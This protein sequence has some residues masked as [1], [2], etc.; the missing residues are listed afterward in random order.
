MPVAR[1]RNQRRRHVTATMP[2]PAPAAAAG[3][4]RRWVELV[5]QLSVEERNALAQLTD[6][7]L[8]RFIQLMTLHAEAKGGRA[9]YRMGLKKFIDHVSRGR[10]K[11][12]EFSRRLCRQLQRVADGTLKRLIVQAP[13]RHGKSEPI[14]RLFPAY[15]LYRHP[16]H[17]CAIIS[18]GASLAQTL[19]RAARANY[20]YA[21]GVQGEATAVQEWLT[22]KGGGVWA[23]GAG[24]SLLGRGYNVGIIDDPYKNAADAASAIYREHLRDWYMTTFRTRAE[25]DA[26]IVIVMQRWAPDDLI[27]WLLEQEK[28]A[29]KEVVRGSEDYAEHWHVIEFS[30]LSEA[31]PETQQEKDRL[32]V[33][34]LLA[35]LAM[36]PI[37]REARSDAAAVEAII[38]DS[39]IPPTCT[40]EPDWRAEGEAL[41]EERYPARVL[42]MLRAR[43]GP[44][45]FGALFQQR[46]TTR[47]GALFT[48]SML[49]SRKFSQ[50]LF[51]GAKF[52]R[53]WDFAATEESLTS[54]DPD[55]TVGALVAKLA[56]GSVCLVDIV[57]GRWH[58]TERDRII[59]ETADSDVIRWGKESFETWGEQEPGSAGVT[60]AGAFIRLLIGHKAFTKKTTGSKVTEAADLAS[61]AGG[62]Q[63]FMMEAAWNGA[64]RREFLDF[65]REGSGIH[66]DIVD[67]T[68]KAFNR[69]A[70]PFAKLAPAQSGSIQSLA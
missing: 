40:L 6:D 23:A 27:G 3:P 63:F 31:I 51:A 38:D 12:F 69:L 35:S 2:E 60:A 50:I 52:V 28:E 45:F 8:A 18:Y 61:F 13:P 33:E 55:W 56:D 44:Y 66:D 41:C 70:K 47:E 68:T 62:G 21:E 7:E 39:R 46:P 15:Y 37:A 49:P 30:A 20:Y 57:R 43:L 67:A 4:P 36:D 53:W 24:G 29:A 22:G 42:R 64:A 9:Q 5:A 48:L 25:P 14:T 32:A 34:A 58:P 16:E 26:A 17:F 10:Y 1:L 19:S 54:D 11:W 65:P 59:K